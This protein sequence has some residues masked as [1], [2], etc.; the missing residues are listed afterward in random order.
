MCPIGQFIINNYMD[1]LVYDSPFLCTNTIN[2]NLHKFLN[3][4]NTSNGKTV[5]RGIDFSNFSFLNFNWPCSVF[6]THHKTLNHALRTSIALYITQIRETNSIL[7]YPWQFHS[8][9]LVKNTP[10][11]SSCC[12]GLLMSLTKES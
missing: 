4:H 10:H 9:E 12:I 2:E 11:I 7:E 6:L 8:H 1:S 5:S 3:Q